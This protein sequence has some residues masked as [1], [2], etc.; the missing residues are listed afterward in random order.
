MINALCT[1]C[2][3]IKLFSKRGKPE[4][5]LICKECHAARDQPVLID[6]NVK[7]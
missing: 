6:E 5:V 4:E 2:G 1:V 3:K 7:Q